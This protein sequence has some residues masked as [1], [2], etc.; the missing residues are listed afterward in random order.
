M[1]L[2]VRIQL[3]LL[4]RAATGMVFTSASAMVGCPPRYSLD[5]HYR[6]KEVRDE[7]VV[8][9]P[10]RIDNALVA[11]GR[12]SLIRCA[13]RLF[14]KRLATSAASRLAPG[15]YSFCRYGEDR[16]GPSPTHDRR[17]CCRCRG[18]ERDDGRSGLMTLGV[19]R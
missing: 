2:T 5:K 16:D 13:L 7:S 19:A 18:D 10:L 4:V 1:R 17:R 14:R 11:A 8:T 3:L 15:L 12:V 9:P 6:G